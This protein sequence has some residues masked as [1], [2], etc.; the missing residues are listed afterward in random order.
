M[1]CTRGLKSPS[2]HRTPFTMSPQP[3]E[4][5]P[6]APERVELPIAKVL[7][8]GDARQHKKVA[9]SGRATEFGLLHGKG[10]KTYGDAETHA[11]CKECRHMIERQ[12]TRGPQS[13]E[14]KPPSKLGHW[15]KHIDN[16]EPGQ[17]Q[18]SDP[19]AGKHAF[20][21]DERFKRAALPACAPIAAMASS[22]NCTST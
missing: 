18:L 12:R 3:I 6:H 11:E 1:L 5:S 16:K 13:R 17:T 4:T 20:V 15:T 9:Q 21:I 2:R 8:D 14:Q 19:A 10:A 7:G 22:A